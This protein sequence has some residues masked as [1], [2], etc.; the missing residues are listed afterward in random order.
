MFAS[1]IADEIFELDPFLFLKNKMSFLSSLSTKSQRL[2]LFRTAARKYSTDPSSYEETAKRQLRDYQKWKQHFRWK[3]SLV[4]Q[5]LW[6]YSWWSVLGLLAYLNLHLK[7]EREAYEAETFVVIDELQ[8]RIDAQNPTP[9]S[10]K[11]SAAKHDVIT[12]NDKKSI[13]F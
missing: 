11:A 4:S 5:T 3:P 9:P 7:Q 8:H 1:T 12:P 2:L 13:F 6:D 10:A